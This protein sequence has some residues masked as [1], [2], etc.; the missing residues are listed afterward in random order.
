MPPIP[1]EKPKAE[2]MPEPSS[3]YNGMIQPNK[4]REGMDVTQSA[5]YWMV[6]EATAK[7]KPPEAKPEGDLPKP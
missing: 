6:R 3:L 5:L 4:P 7:E 1:G 2:E